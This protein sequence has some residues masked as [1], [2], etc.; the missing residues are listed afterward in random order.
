MTKSDF[1]FSN[2]GRESKL[3][4]ALRL[5]FNTEQRTPT[6][7]YFW[8]LHDVCGDVFS[9]SNLSNKTSHLWDS[10][11]NCRQNLSHTEQRVNTIWYGSVRGLLKLLTHW[12]RRS[13]GENNKLIVNFIV[14]YLT[15]QQL[16]FQAFPL[17]EQ[18]HKNTN[19]ITS[20]SHLVSEALLRIHRYPTYSISHAR[21]S[22]EWPN[23]SQDRTPN[24]F[25]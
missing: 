21:S 3:P 14:R 16:W 15:A 1:G 4:I 22:A 19:F 2:R 24:N 12:A 18:L 7:Y 11:G 6:I 9:L 8:Q 13:H 17:H 5:S 25:L 20:L 10:S 23:N